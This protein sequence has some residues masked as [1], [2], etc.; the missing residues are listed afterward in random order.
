MSTWWRDHADFHMGMLL[1][2]DGPFRSS[3]AQNTRGAP[4]PCDP[5]PAGLFLGGGAL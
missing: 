4:L 2:V 3:D 1:S 5:P